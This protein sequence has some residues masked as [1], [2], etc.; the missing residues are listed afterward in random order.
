MRTIICVW[1]AIV[2]GTYACLWL[3]A[4]V[5]AQFPWLLTR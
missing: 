4:D 1:L 2:A 3:L 5:V